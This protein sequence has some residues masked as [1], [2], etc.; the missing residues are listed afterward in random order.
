MD[1]N[2]QKD[3]YGTILLKVQKLTVV[4]A[5]AP[6]NDTMDEERDEF[7]NQLQDTVSTCNRNDMIVVKGDLNAEVGSNNTN[8]EEVM[9]K[10]GVMNN[11][12]KG[13]VTSVVQMGSSQSSP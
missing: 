8:R 11:N 6:T 1:A 13:Y 12:G 4:Q 5:Y 10:F 2:Q 3:Y 7:Y 9:G